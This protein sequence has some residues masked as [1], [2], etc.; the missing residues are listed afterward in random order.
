[1]L[2]QFEVIE[3]R[4]LLPIVPVFNYTNK[5]IVPWSKE[6]NQLLIKEDIINQGE[7]FEYLNSKGEAKKGKVTGGA[8]ITGKASGIMVLDLDRNHGDNTKDGVEAYKQL[9]NSLE[10]TEEEQQQ[11]FNTFTVKTPNGGL[12]LYFKY[13]KGLKN[14]SNSDLSIDIRTDG[15][16]IIT[17][18]SLR[19]IKE[20]I[21]EYTVYKDNPIHD[22]PI[23]LF[24]N[25]TEYFGL[26][27]VKGNKPNEY[28]K[29]PGRPPKN[30]QYYTVTN[31]G[32]RDDALI[33]Y[34]GRMITQPMFRN[35]HEL[36]PLAM[37]YNQCYIK[38]PLEVK[39]VETKVNS[40]LSYAK[41]VY[42][43]DKGK[44]INGSLVK[45]V[46]SKSSS[47]VKGNMLYI[48]NEELGIYE[49]M[50]AR[51]QLK[52]YYDHVIIDE[53]VDPG[54]A[55][56]FAKTIHSIADNY[57]ELFNY[58]NRY[59][60]CLN[61]IV[62][63]ETDELLEFNP[64]YKL[65]TKFNGNYTND[66]DKYNEDYNNSKFKSFL[67][68]ILDSDTILTLQEAWGVMLCP[69]A[70]KVQ[71]C[72]IYKGEGANGKSSL[73][74]IQTALLHNK[75]MSV[76]G[77][78]LGKFGDEFIMAMAEGR[79]VN[80]VRDDTVEGKIN[81]VFKSAVCG[82]EVTVNK[83]NRDHVQMKFNMA[84]FYGL[85]RMP[86]TNDKSYG[87]FRRPIFIPFNVRFGT[88]L[89]VRT[90]EADKVGIP[91]I[92]E[93]IIKSEMDIVFMWAYEGL[94]RLKLNN[95]KIT[96]SEASIQ[97][98]EEY[99]EEADSSYAFY[100]N[101]LIKKQGNNLHAK[102]LHLKYTEWCYEEGI[103]SPMNPTQFGRQMASNGHKKGIGMAHDINKPG[104]TVFFNL[105]HKKTT[106]IPLENNKV[107]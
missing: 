16:I 7:W 1:M 45:F 65:D 60:N 76:C 67:E 52:L 20:D 3:T 96:Q 77:I 71:Q 87:F 6:E 24:D 68:N 81:G 17:P 38:P 2:K 70:T 15:G 41:P 90:G 73:F 56:K 48:Y 35:V 42:C 51:D 72:F 88:E 50:D 99:K 47:Y 23:P 46:L 92:V 80:I 19:K 36:L 44:I 101:C 100:K 74:D 69:N 98:M 91:G 32:G 54:K 106:S 43:T 28:K 33:K 83:K 102:T 57:K 64:K 55:D 62:D 86:V 58:E 85:N 107:F 53:D 66:I 30:K 22:M 61:G 84:W 31:E 94:K 40:I 29:K 37:M 63:T 26:N 97:E 103:N 4:N 10:M 34:L 12:H 78:G 79:R 14:S 105:D 82:E 5:P 89:Q 93:D 75:D 9:I 59:I 104:N 13:R 8:L 49:Y 27:K 39:E 21:K 25:L 18:G 95:W 11:A